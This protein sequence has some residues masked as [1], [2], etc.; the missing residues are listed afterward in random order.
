MF[1]QPHDFRD[2]SEA[3]FRL[4]SELSDDQLCRQTQ[5]KHWTIN[6]IITH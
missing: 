6:A 5:F 2:E 3:L 1:Q 4:I